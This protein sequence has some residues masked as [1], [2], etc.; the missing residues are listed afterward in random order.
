MGWWNNDAP[1]RRASNARVR[2][3]NIETVDA[4]VVERPGPQSALPDDRPRRRDLEP[5]R[6]WR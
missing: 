1:R 4:F 6:P 2:P 3:H 5:R